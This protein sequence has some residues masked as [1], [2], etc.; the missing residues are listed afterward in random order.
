MDNLTQVAYC[1]PCSYDGS[2]LLTN[3]HTERFNK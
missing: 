1:Q 3:C 2:Q